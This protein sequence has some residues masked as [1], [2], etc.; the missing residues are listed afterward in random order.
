MFR[1]KTKK[2]EFLWVFYDKNIKIKVGPSMD[3]SGFFGVKSRFEKRSRNNKT[4]HQQTYNLQQTHTSQLLMN[5]ER[6][7]GVA[8]LIT[9]D[10]KQLVYAPVIIEQ[11]IKFDE[12]IFHLFL[13]HEGNPLQ[14]TFFEQQHKNGTAYQLSIAHKIY[15][16]KQRE[17]LLHFLQQKLCLNMKQSR[18]IANEYPGVDSLAM[19]HANKGNMRASAII[20]KFGISHKKT[21]RLWYY[22]HYWKKKRLE[23]I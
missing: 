8:P 9:N 13:D 17:K 2:N 15:A 7:C 1:Q 22:V 23:K 10:T 6:K 21:A 16:S 11:R 3:S 14:A 12:D 18:E 19:L 4:K 20:R 5:I